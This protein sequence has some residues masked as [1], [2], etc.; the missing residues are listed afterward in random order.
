MQSSTFFI[1]CLVAALAL[2]CSAKRGF[3]GQRP[4][5]VPSS[6]DELVV[7][8]DGDT[9]CVE[10]T[11]AKKVRAVCVPQGRLPSP[12]CDEL[13]CE[14]LTCLVRKRGKTLVAACVATSCDQLECENDTVCV[15]RNKGAITK[16]VC[17]SGKLVSKTILSRPGVLVN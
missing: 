6:C 14:N 4:G 15:V 10:V 5:Q 16:P 12:S 1:V 3:G 7:P 17:I 13:D 8:C 11:L 9:E 2:V